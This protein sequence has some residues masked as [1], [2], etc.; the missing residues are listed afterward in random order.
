MRRYAIP[1]ARQIGRLLAQGESHGW[2]WL[3]QT[4]YYYPRLLVGVLLG[5]FTLGA[6]SGVTDAILSLRYS[7]WWPVPVAS[8]MLVSL[9]AVADVERRVGRGPGNQILKRALGITGFG[10]LYAAL[11]AAAIYWAA[12]GLGLTGCHYW[13]VPMMWAS[14][15]LTLGFVFQLFW[16]DRSIGEPL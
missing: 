10:A 4:A 13:P 14:V 12:R 8:L 5:F 15:A 3:R 9:L 2:R 16:Q 11:L 1:E 7:V 6:S